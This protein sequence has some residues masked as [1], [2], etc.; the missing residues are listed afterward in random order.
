[1]SIWIWPTSVSAVVELSAAMP[2]AQL[3]QLVTQAYEAS[4][5]G[6][7]VLVLPQSLRDAVD[8]VLDESVKRL[9][10]QVAGVFYA[11]PVEDEAEIMKLAPTAPLVIAATNQ[12][13]ARL[14]AQQIRYRSADGNVDRAERVAATPAENAA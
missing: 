12:L 13:R 6:A 1:M 2:E 5:D 4:R 3:R 7:V 14:D 9:G 11:D 8:V 10:I